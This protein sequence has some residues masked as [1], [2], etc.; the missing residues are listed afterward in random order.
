MTAIA[1]EVD[2]IT[3]HPGV[4]ER[5][6]AEADS[7]VDAENYVASFGAAG[8]L[9]YIE[10]VVNETLRLHPI[11]PIFFLEPIEDEVIGGVT[12]PSGTPIFILSG[13]A[14][15]RD[16]H[17]E[18]SA[19]FD[20]DRWLRDASEQDGVHDARAFLPFGA[21]PRFCPGRNLSI[22]EAKMVMA[23]VVG[24]FEISRPPAAAPVGELFAFTLQPPD[25]TV[26]LA[27]RAPRS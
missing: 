11:A 21:G 8:Q 15:K 24:N 10:A 16:S 7:V 2:C 9:P 12:V 5:M 6:R 14:A 1:A 25:L 20:P 19:E 4:Q 22:L 18:K 23:M 3:E 13:Y 26:R 27:S 17:F